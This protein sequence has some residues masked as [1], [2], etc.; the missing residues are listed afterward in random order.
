MTTP[1][2][3]LEVR[4]LLWEQ[5]QACSSR[6][7]PTEEPS[8]KNTANTFNVSVFSTIPP[9]IS[10]G[11]GSYSCAGGVNRGWLVVQQEDGFVI[12]KQEFVLNEEMEDLAT[13][14]AEAF[15]ET[16]L[17]VLLANRVSG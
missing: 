2:C 8:M 10:H 14:A 5:D 4:R 15:R 11:D 13:K 12:D 16:L 1:G 3:S 17:K 7:T 6:V 9:Q